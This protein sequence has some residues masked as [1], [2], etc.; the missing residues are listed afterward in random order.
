MKATR[1]IDMVTLEDAG[2]FELYGDN[3]KTMVCERK[4]SVP[5]LPSELDVDADTFS[6]DEIYLFVCY[7]RAGWDLELIS[8]T[9]DIPVMEL[10]AKKRELAKLLSRVEDPRRRRAVPTGR[11]AHRPSSLTTEQKRQIRELRAGG[12]KHTA[13][14]LAVGCGV[15]CVRHVLDAGGADVQ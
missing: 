9:L 1:R 7:L 10:S 13:I 3:R 2:V 4:R 8:Q 12:A 6:Q 11:P 15:G 14:A 5:V